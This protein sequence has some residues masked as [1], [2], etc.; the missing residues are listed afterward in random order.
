[1]RSLLSATK[2]LV[3]GIAAALLAASITG[4]DFGTL[5]DL[6]QDDAV[7]GSDEVST[8]ALR[9]WT[10]YEKT[11]DDVKKAVAD[12]TGVVDRAGSR[13]LQVT[14]DPLTKDNL[15]VATITRDSATAQGMLIITELDCSMDAITKL[16]VAKNQPDLYPKTYDAY[17]RTYQSDVNAF[18][19]NASPTLTWKTDYTATAINRTYKATLTGGARFLPAAAPNG[20]PILLSRTILDA[21]ATFISG[22]DAEFNQDYQM[23]AYYSVAPTKVVHFYALWREFRV[24]SLTSHDNLYI[25]VVLGNLVDFDVRTSKICRDGL[26]PAPAF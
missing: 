24:A 7:Q 4:C 3:Y 12:I 8:Q 21:P 6:S 5:D 26:K 23:E 9:L 18:L 20:G 2:S 19:S 10:T 13:P 1:M 22:D 14:I 11:D 17:T 16:V 15:G 25:N